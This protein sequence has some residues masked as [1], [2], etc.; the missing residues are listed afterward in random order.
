[1]QDWQSINSL[2]RVMAHADELHSSLYVFFMAEKLLRIVPSNLFPTSYS[3]HLFMETAQTCNMF[4]QKYLILVLNLV[5]YTCILYTRFIY[6]Y[7][8]ILQTQL[9]FAN[10]TEP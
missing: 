5:L 6:M 9:C 1:M 4:S 3:P 8:H 7:L 2:H 10:L